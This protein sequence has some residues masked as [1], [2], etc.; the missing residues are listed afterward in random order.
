MPY[1][2]AR[3]FM[4]REGVNWWR[5]PPKSPDCNLIENLWHELKTQRRKSKT[6]TELVDGIL[7]FLA[8]VD[9]AKCRKYIHYLLPRVIELNGGP[10]LV[11]NPREGF[12]SWSVCLSVCEQ[13]FSR[14]VSAVGTERGGVDKHHWRSVQQETGAALATERRSAASSYS[15]GCVL[16]KDRDCVKALTTALYALK[17]QQ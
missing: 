1:G 4:E 2:H 9:V 15:T 5:A 16:I 14:A 10:T 7:E 3:E 13:V 8:T 11:I 6:K 12:C 17:R